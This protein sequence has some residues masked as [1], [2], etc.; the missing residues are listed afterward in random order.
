M[1]EPVPPPSLPPEAALRLAE[2]ARACK[3]AA[4]AVALYPGSHPAIGAALS[5]LAQATTRLTAEGP[6]V[7]TVRVDT[8][9]LDGAIALKPDPA[10][11]ELAD[12]LYRHLIGGL[13]VTGAADAE[14]WRALLLLLARTPEE[15][16][17][18][19]GIAHLW[20]TA[21]GPSVEIQEIDYAEVLRE[22]HGTAVTIDRI[23]AAAIGGPQLQ[24]D[25]DGLRSLIELLRNAEQVDELMARLG[26]ASSGGTSNRATAVVNLLRNIAA[27]AAAQG[28]RDPV[29]IEETLQQLGRVTARLSAD[30]M[31]DLLG[32]RAMPATAGD[33]V[34]SVLERM[35]D[36]EVSQFV[37]NSVIAERGATQRLAQAF[38]ALAPDGDRQRHL[39]ALA[40]D[41][42]SESDLGED[43]NF[44]QLW[45]QVESMVTSYSDESYVSAAYG[46]ELFASQNRA[47]DVEQTSDDPAERV[48]AWL[49][50]VSDSALRGLDHQLLIDLLAIE[51][52]APRWRDVADAAAAHADDLVR[53]GYLDQA[54]ELA[55]AI[56]QEAGRVEG[57]SVFLASVLERF[58]RGSM[59]KHVA[60][61]LRTASDGAFA[62]FERLCHAIGTPLVAPLAE[63]LSAEQD[64]RSRRRLRDVLVGFGA[65]GRDVV[66]Q[67]MSAPN[68]EVR[69]TAA[70]LLREFG[71]SEGLREL[72][73]L[74]TDS[75]P[76]VQREAIQGLMLNGS[77]E[78]AVILLN[79]L[80]GSSGRARQTLVQE[81]AGI[82][83]A[84]AAPLLCYLVRTLKRSAFPQ[85]YRSAIESLGTLADPASV[86]ALKE[87]LHRG[88]WWA[89]IRTRRLRAAAAT[90]LRRIGTAPAIEALR[91][92]STSGSRGARAAARAEL[93]QLS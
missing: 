7:L 38:Q 35:G 71:G 8:L 87:A 51:D 3:A 6:F 75:E 64:S 44:D 65:Q 30:E 42:A 62:R 57:R 40:H 18:D 26:E 13:T 72:I 33:P 12:V 79:A 36:A 5:R 82:R 15:V 23:V 24:L 89:P 31:L 74:L 80:Q 32:K 70:F 55:D 76:L 17:A 73:P 83:D 34:G 9:L 1:L 41:R 78:A 81:L 47:V 16:R 92:V 68:W 91:T 25:D 21:G 77:D 22:K 14:S 52:D 10:I 58:A 90:A 67:L 54:W 19:G 48:A 2:F 86:D 49:S 29:V 20:A 39:L 37:A 88:E 43:Q 28:G 53:V 93:A 59:M 84:K 60:A 11:A 45:G 4:R 56:I 50:S 66:Q 69:R 46:R 85:V 61:H 63:A 27:A